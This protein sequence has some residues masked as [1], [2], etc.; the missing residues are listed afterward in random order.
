MTHGFFPP[1]ATDLSRSRWM[2]WQ[3][4]IDA[5]LTTLRCPLPLPTLIQRGP[6]L[7]WRFRINRPKRPLQME[8]VTEIF[9][10]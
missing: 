3:E 1:G 4:M 8:H 6:H 10:S 9:L 2:A 7:R 5:V